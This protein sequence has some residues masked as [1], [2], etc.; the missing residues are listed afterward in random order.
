M[1]R[2][3]LDERMLLVEFL[4]QITSGLIGPL[5]AGRRAFLLSLAL[6]AAV[7]G[8]AQ[9]IPLLPVDEAALE[10]EEIRRYTVEIIVFTY[11]DSVSVGSEMFIPEPVEETLE[12]LE[13][14]SVPYYGDQPAPSPEPPPTIAPIPTINIEATARPMTIYIKEPSIGP[15]KDGA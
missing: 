12:P 5:R 15:M 4:L 3:Y 1:V 7:T 8:A 14:G 6:L 11:D 2:A 13:L 10:E 9:E